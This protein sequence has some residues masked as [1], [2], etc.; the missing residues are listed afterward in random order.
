LIEPEFH[1]AWLEQI[2]NFG[3]IGQQR[4][5]AMSFLTTAQPK[6]KKHFRPLL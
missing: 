2:S 5:P 4:Y 3:Q 6:P 1:F